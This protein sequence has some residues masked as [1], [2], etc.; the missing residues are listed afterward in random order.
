MEKSK[1]SSNSVC[2]TPSSEPFRICCI[3]DTVKGALAPSLAITTI[4]VT[5][6]NNNNNNSIRVYLRANLT[7][8]RPIT[9][10]A[11]IHRTTQK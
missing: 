5:F 7:E 4:T 6:N 8:Q 10:L 9:K 2:Y 1:K 3:V 11:R